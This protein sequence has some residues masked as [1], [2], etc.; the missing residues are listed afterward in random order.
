VRG[1]EGIPLEF[2]E[3]R[4]TT[5]GT[6]AINLNRASPEVLAAVPGLDPAA[7]AELLTL[8]RS[9]TELG[10]S[11]ILVSRLTPA[12]R[13]ALFPRFQEFSRTVIYA[14][15]RLVLLA[16]GGVRGYGSVAW[17]RLEVV[18]SGARLAVVRREVQ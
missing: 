7:V 15:G 12:S 17:A 13:R 4:F 14:P 2:L 16:E 8:R 18:P 5:V 10:T 11:D 1:F 9:G 3:H 6:G